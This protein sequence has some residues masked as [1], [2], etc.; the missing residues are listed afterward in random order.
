[1]LIR[2]VRSL[3]AVALCAGGLTALSP[4]APALAMAVPTIG[5]YAGGGERGDGGLAAH[6]LVD[7]HSAT[8]SP[9]GSA[10]LLDGPRLR[11][12]EEFGKIST[13]RAFYEALDKVVAGDQHVFVRDGAFVL[14]LDRTSGDTVRETYLPGLLDFDVAGEVV[15]AVTATGV[16]RS[17]EGQTWTRLAG[18]GAAG[19]GDGGSALDAT[20]SGLRSI[21]VA[22]NGVYV[23]QGNAVRHVDGGV[24]TTVAGG[25][26]G[27]AADAGDGQPATDAS[28][29]PEQLSVVGGALAGPDVVYVAHGGA[30]A[31][32]RRFAVGGDI[33]AF[34][35]PADCAD[36][37]IGAADAWKFLVACGRV[38]T[39][40]TTTGEGTLFAGYDGTGSPDGV[41]VQ[42]S[43]ES[44]VGGVA[45]DAT[46]RPYYSAA[47]RVRHVTPQLTIETIAGGGD[48]ADGWG[49]GPAAGAKLRPGK[50]AAAPDGSLYVVD[51]RPGDMRVRR[52]KDGVVSTVAG[53]GAGTAADGGPATAAAF[54]WVT[55][56]AVDGDGVVWFA[57]DRRVWRI[58]GGA[59]DLVTTLPAHGGCC[60][61]A[62]DPYGGRMLAILG[63]SIQALAAD[64]TLT[65]AA[66]LPGWAGAAGPDGAV[67]SSAGWVRRG[68]VLTRFFGAGTA[69]NA[70]PAV[71]SS[72]SITQAYVDAEGLF[73]FADT[74]RRQVR[75]IDA[76]PAPVVPAVGSLGATPGPG[77]VAFEPD[78]PS[79]AR[80]DV[81]A[82]VGTAPPQL[83][84]DG[85]HI[86]TW[87]PTDAASS[88]FEAH[89]LDGQAHLAPTPHAFTFFYQGSAVDFLVRTAVV[90]PLADD[91]APPM[92][93]NLAL[94]LANDTVTFVEPTT[95]DFSQ[96]AVRWAYGSTP[97]ATI[98]DGS[99]AP[100]PPLARYS[101]VAWSVFSM[102]W[103]SN[104][105]PP[106]TILMPK[107]EEVAGAPSPAFA[108][109]DSDEPNQRLT[110][111]HRGGDVRYAA[112]TTAPATM[113]D[114]LAPFCD[115]SGGLGPTGR[116]VLVDGLTYGQRYAFAVFTRVPGGQHYTRGTY[117]AVFGANTIPDTFTM[118]ATPASVVTGSLVTFQGIVKQGGTNQAQA[119]RRVELWARS[120]PS[121]TYARV[122]VGRT[123]STGTYALS[124]RPK[125]HT[126]YQVRTG[127]ADPLAPAMPATAARLVKA[128]PKVSGRLSATRV[129]VGG[130]V[131]VYGSIAPVG[132]RRLVLQHLTPSGWSN[133]VGK[134]TD[135]YGRTYY[136]VTRP[137]G[138]HRYRWIAPASSVLNGATGPS[139]SFTVG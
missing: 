71:D 6:A 120:L 87:E 58:A 85:T 124:A 8:M 122:A 11:K 123:T 101:D 80:Y 60:G 69:G 109:Y 52:I 42:G 39:Y 70:G 31:S 62:Y 66:E 128:T 131:R 17:G 26:S 44:G 84:G 63:P 81:W 22:N 99:P 104:I 72:G 112:G 46:G 139:L 65:P 83:P 19:W 12:V 78:Q 126:Y 25:E 132:A 119:L 118:S 47:D 37:R 15:Y 96:A 34:A 55:A 115:C 106:A 54:S 127:V 10:Y 4:A 57:E 129:P 68:D 117:T 61:L 111:F 75:V 49:D 51:Y 98:T 108:G 94:D 136:D 103:S 97:P 113:A 13:L 121:A 59:L 21:A 7:A 74:Q 43:W 79:G 95:P 53:G 28:V 133:V 32:I 91:V 138:T 27:A 135:G 73:V 24:I 45:P 76:L 116:V 102:D 88:S 110:L 30:S 67:F 56:V 134:T 82:N 107:L 1:M 50:L 20:M 16:W 137:R 77:Y 18:G 33:E 3:L 114:G 125:T 130:K 89:H 64:G 23:G 48:P 14:G 2:F 86:R 93:G 40:D 35:A 9:G 36:L 92:V 105:S 5:A 38:D 41:K 100:L 90:T 29:N